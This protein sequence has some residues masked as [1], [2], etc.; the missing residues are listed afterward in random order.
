M[1]KIRSGTDLP[2]V[3][4]EVV[5]RDKLL[6][7]ASVHDHDPAAVQDD[8]EPVGDGKEHLPDGTSSLTST[9]LS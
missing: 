4:E 9:T 3:P 6:D 2:F 8:L 1:I 5:R 7:V